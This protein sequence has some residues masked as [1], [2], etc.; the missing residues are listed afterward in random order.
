MEGQD[1]KTGEVGQTNFWLSA[2]EIRVPW[3]I[4]A[5]AGVYVFSLFFFSLLFYLLPLPPAGFYAYVLSSLAAGVAATAF[6]FD[7]M[8]RA[9]FFDVGLHR[10]GLAGGLAAG[11]AYGGAL[12]LFACMILLIA[13]AA[14]LHPAKFTG[15]A[16]V[17]VLADGVGLFLLGAAGEELLM[18]GYPFQAL[19]T[20]HGAF[21]T[22]LVTSIFFAGLHIANPN[23]TVL[24]LVN[25]FLA[26]VLLGSAYLATG[27][28]WFP[29]GLHF[30]W[31]FIQGSVLGFPVSGLIRESVYVAVPVGPVGISGGL[32]GLEG[33]AIA[34]VVLALGAAVLWI[35][36][37][38]RRLPGNP[39]PGFRVSR[40]TNS[41]E[42]SAA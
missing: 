26:G 32:F 10:R 25:I 15:G 36:A 30:G 20:R 1:V 11:L 22:L 28:L 8:E 9:S 40:E 29:I 39:V 35:P 41:E 16:A 3:K 24:S 5:F 37:V 19:Y 42:D 7:G 38:V 12:A 17:S 4:T 18:R 34:T 13:G 31:N 33:S 2:G 27:S 21:W 6:A 14:Y 23:I